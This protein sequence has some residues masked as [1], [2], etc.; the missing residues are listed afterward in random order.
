M[1]GFTSGSAKLA[2]S[3]GEKS[4]GISLRDG[5]GDENPDDE[6]ENEL[7]PVEPAPTS[8]IRKEA[9]NKRTN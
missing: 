3:A 1:V 6:G 7:D 9:T 5:E 2:S 8:S 4:R